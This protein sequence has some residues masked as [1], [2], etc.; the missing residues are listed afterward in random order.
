MDDCATVLTIIRLQ[1]G[2]GIST[3]AGI[4]DF[5]SPDTGLYANLARLNLPAPEAVFSIE[6]FRANPR[7]FYALRKEMHHDRCKP[8]ITHVFL[9]LLYEKGRLLKV[10]TQNIDGL[11]RAAGVPAEMVVEAHG[12]FASQRCIECKAAYP[13]DLMQK[14]IEADDVPLCPD[15]MGI[16][17]PDVVF[18]GEP[19][20][21]SFLLNRTL[22]AAADLCIVMGTSLSV[23][24]F[25]SLPSMCSD[26]TPRVLI[27]LTPAG[28]IGSRSDDVVLLGECDDGVMK[29]AEALGWLEELEALWSKINPEK[30][31]AALQNRKKKMEPIT[32][33][34]QLREEVEKVTEEV[35]HTLDLS[36][37]HEER[38]RAQLRAME[39]KEIHESK[40]TEDIEKIMRPS[41]PSAEKI[42]GTTDVNTQGA[43]HI[44]SERQTEKSKSDSSL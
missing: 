38:V 21:S 40:T 1:V 15:C 19:L 13:L 20:P 6:Y 25:A 37:A 18:F 9:R 10:F 3:A 2:A 7:P 11:E 12:S 32:R 5:R 8:T 34:E 16:V 30:A 24:P 41:S 27:N 4:P 17:K 31:T 39:V 14:A 33:D 29:L 36:Q 26:G 44:T 43:G 23:Q 28:G 42:D 22:P 35:E